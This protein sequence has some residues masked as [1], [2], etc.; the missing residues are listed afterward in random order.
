MRR[1]GRVGCDQRRAM[2]ARPPPL[3]SGF[4]FSHYWPFEDTVNDSQGAWNL[5]PVGDFQYAVGAPDKLKGVKLFDQNH[6][7]FNDDFTGRTA[8]SVTGWFYACTFAF[9]YVFSIG[10]NPVSSNAD[11]QF[12]LARCAAKTSSWDAVGRI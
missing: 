6:A 10:G 8:F 9:K 2:G 7:W 4:A 11:I 1:W 5:T 12:G 3:M